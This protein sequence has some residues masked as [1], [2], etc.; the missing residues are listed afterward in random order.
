[1]VLAAPEMRD[2]LKGARNW[3]PASRAKI[4][5]SKQTNRQRYPDTEEKQ[6]LTSRLE[7]LTQLSQ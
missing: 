6:S 5:G 1:V 2:L 4:L 7:N 3:W